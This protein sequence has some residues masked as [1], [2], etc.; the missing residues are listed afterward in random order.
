VLTKT[1]ETAI[2]ALLYLHR[3]GADAPVPPTQIAEDLGSSASYMAKVA[4]LLTKAGVLRAH[5]GVKGGVMLS[6]PV[7][8][9]TLLE[10]VEACQG[11]IL[12]N[13]CQDA[14]HIEWVCGFHRAMYE[15]HRAFVG[16]LAEWTL[17]DIA[18]KP[19][20]ARQLQGKVHCRLGCLHQTPAA[21]THPTTT[22]KAH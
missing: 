19:A 18:D 14:D 6:R 3:E 17:A 5:R 1:S 2:L 4:A 8:E 15:L 11:K 9:I 10:V 7:A 21:K 16:V 20:P 22:R 13:Y 12:A